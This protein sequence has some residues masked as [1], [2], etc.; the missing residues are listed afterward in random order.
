MRTL[1]LTAAALLLAGPA[2]ADEIV[3]G[4]VLVRWR[5]TRTQALLPDGVHTLRRLSPETH[6]IATTPTVEAT[7]A[8][9]DRL[10]ARADVVY[11][12]PDYVRQRSGAPVAPNDPMYKFQWGL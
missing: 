5:S 7:R 8:L 4:R 6:L 1:V 3:P 11:A 12:E 2:A 10:N 9:I